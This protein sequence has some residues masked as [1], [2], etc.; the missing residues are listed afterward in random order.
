MRDPSDKM[1][2]SVISMLSLYQVMVGIGVPTAGQTNVTD[3]PSTT[4]VEAGKSCGSS[5]GAIKERLI[6]LTIYSNSNTP[7]KFDEYLITDECLLNICQSFF[8]PISKNILE[9]S[10][11]CDFFFSKIVIVYKILQ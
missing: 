6:V 1:T 2:G 9:M 5:G 8:N 10:V 7:P 4:F 11:N 3:S